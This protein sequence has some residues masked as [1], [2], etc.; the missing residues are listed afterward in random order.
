MKTLF[1]RLRRAKKRKSLKRLISIIFAAWALKYGRI[2]QTTETE[3]SF[4]ELVSNKYPYQ[5]SNEYLTGQKS[6]LTYSQEELDAL[7]LWNVDKKVTLVVGLPMPHSCQH[8]LAV[9]EENL[10]VLVQENNISKNIAQKPRITLIR[11]KSDLRNSQWIKE[12]V[13]GIRG[14]DDEKLIRSIISKVSE[15]DWDIT[16]INKILKKLAEVTL[17]IGTSD[18]LLRILAELE[19]PIAES[20]IFVE[21]WVPQL[22]RHRKLNEVEKNKYSSPSIDFLLD[23]TKC[24]G[25]REAYNMPRSVSENFETKAVKKLSK[26]SLKNPRLKKEYKA[27]KDLL[28]EGVHPVNLSEKST[29][30]SPTKVLVKKPEGRYLVD[31]SDTNAEIVAVSSRTNEKCM[32]KFKT[33][34]NELYNL[35]L[36]GY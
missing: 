24:Y 13:S 7:G 36:K 3:S 8:T 20:P 32:S 31:V 25:H 14:G 29:Y 19:K 1:I 21:G 4:T 17:E 9:P 16:S 10:N 27:V 15:A 2:T 22:P 26:I 5:D 28:K 12:F 18:K 34:M 23:S 33:L 6:E 11:I 35:D 30:V